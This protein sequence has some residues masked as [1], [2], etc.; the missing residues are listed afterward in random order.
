MSSEDIEPRCAICGW[1]L[2][3]DVQK[4][5]VR[6]NCSQ[7]PWPARFYDP[8]RADREYGHEVSE[9]QLPLPAVAL[10][11]ER[12]KEQCKLYETQLKAAEAALGIARRE[13]DEAKRERDVYAE[14]LEESNRNYDAL[15]QQLDAIQSAAPLFTAVQAKPRALVRDDEDGE[16]ISRYEA[17][18]CICDAGGYGVEQTALEMVGALPRFKLASPSRADR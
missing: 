8:E 16:Y 17:I 2:V 9:K 15:K 13:Q 6:G 1:P 18:R 4:G 14:Q 5:C 11:C 12:Y 10:E 3:E 7:R